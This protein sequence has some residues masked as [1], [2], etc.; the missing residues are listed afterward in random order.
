MAVKWFNIRSG[1][2]RIAETEPHIAALWSSSDHSPNVTQGQDFGWR[3]APEVVVEMKRIRQD[4]HTLSEIAARIGKNVD[5]VTEPDILL[6]ISAQTSV[7][8]APVAGQDDYESVYDDEVR[9]LTRGEDDTP[10]PNAATLSDDELEAELARRKGAQNT[11]E[12][13][14]FHSKSEE[15]RVKAQRGE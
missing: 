5:E 15:R 3:L 13:Q 2:T 1:E 8:N 12:Q 4:F 14:E 6:H 10:G 7:D 9:R 11:S